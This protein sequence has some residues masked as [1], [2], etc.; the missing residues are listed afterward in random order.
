MRIETSE[1][2]EVAAIVQLNGHLDMASAPDVKRHMAKAVEK[3]QNRIVVDLGATPTIDSSGLAALVST[4]KTCRQAGGDLHLASASSQAQYV[5]QLAGLDRVFPT[6]ESVEA[7]LVH[8]DERF[9]ESLILSGDVGQIACLR[10]A[11]GRVSS[12]ADSLVPGC[13]KALRISFETVVLE[14]AADVL[15]HVL[16]PGEPGALSADLYLTSAEA[17]ATLRDH[18][19][20][21]DALPAEG[22]T[23][24]V[25]DAAARGLDAFQFERLPRQGNR[26]TIRQLLSRGGSR[27]LAKPAA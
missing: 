4:L 3:G 15:R 6:F 22:A 21:F 27:S 8:I 24:S 14:I 26:W 18:G 20:R 25:F 5:I 9:R 7:A 10:A 19:S 17:V 1:R 13:G 16:Q 11:L 23:L 12:V 2:S